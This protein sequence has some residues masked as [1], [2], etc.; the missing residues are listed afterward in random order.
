MDGVEI[1][2]SPFA[3]TKV[4]TSTDYVGGVTYVKGVVLSTVTTYQYFFATGD[5]LAPG[6]L[7]VTS[8]RIMGPNVTAAGY[9]GVTVS[10]VTAQQVG[11]GAAVYYTLSAQSQVQVV[12][13]NLAGRVIAQSPADVQ[14]AGMQTI[15]WNGRNQA[16]ALAP[17][18]IYLVQITAQSDDGTI[19]QSLCSVLLRH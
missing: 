9:A 10:G 1:A 15:R 3:M 16:G 13:Y 7:P 8:G 6:R 4:G 11:T 17:A 2:G 5:G 12:I 18:G 19:A 14:E